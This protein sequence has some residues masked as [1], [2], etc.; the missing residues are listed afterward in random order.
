M[1]ETFLL[2]FMRVAV[3]VTRVE[4]AF[5][6]D[7]SLNVLGTINLGLEEIETAYLKS[8]RQSIDDQQ[9]IITDNYAMTLDPAKA[10]VTNQSFPQLRTVV[11]IPVK[12]HGVVCLDQSVRRGILPKEKI[13]KLMELANSLLKAQ[14][15][16]LDEEGILAIYRE[17]L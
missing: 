14:Q 9:S 16:E 5:A 8:A 7:I 6:V 15:T 13:D 1:S 17:S 12:D 2:N 3:E 4:R 11:F 10:P